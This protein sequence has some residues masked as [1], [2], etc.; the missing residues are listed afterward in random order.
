RFRK[1]ARNKD[2]PVV[3]PARFCNALNIGSHLARPLLLGTEGEGP[4]FTTAVG[5]ANVGETGNFIRHGIGFGIGL[6]VATAV[7]TCLRPQVGAYRS[8]AKFAAKDFE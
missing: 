2:Y 3:A 7:R 5:V 1:T 8:L 4:S 6:A